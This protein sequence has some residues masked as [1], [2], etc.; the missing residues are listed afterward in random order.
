MSSLVRSENDYEDLLGQWSDLESGLGII[1]SNPENA[2]E[3]QRRIVQYDLWLQSLFTR[4]PD[5]GLYLLF[6]LAGNSPV[7]YSASHA[8]VCATLCHLVA[9]EL[10]TPAEERNSLV[11]AALTMNIAMTRLQD[12]LANQSEKP[13]PLQQSLI[14][15]HPV[16]GSLMLSK[17]GVQEALWLDIVTKHHD[18]RSG[19]MLNLRMS[20]AERLA[21][22]LRTVDRYAAMISPRISR[23]GRSASESA[24]ATMEH[25]KVKN[26]VVAQAMVRAVGL[27]PPGTFVRLDS[28]DL[29]VVVRR[30]STLNQPY[31]A[32][33]GRTN[34][35]I[36]TMPRLHCTAK[37]APHIRTA[38]AATAAP[39]QLNHFH[40]L[41]L[42][43]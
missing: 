7:G 28:G 8:L 14:L 24:R 3:F 11:R 29:G 15:S 13:T 23:A 37:G 6:Q 30:S 31:V 38:L 43:A 22:I 9:Q 39:A 4:E 34:G 10:G 26:E 42:A 2:E 5:L 19:A 18:D 40:I 35:D 27:C 12:E 1:L 32:I 33:V 17:L 41:Q 20:P 21:H 36:L 25:S 16:Q